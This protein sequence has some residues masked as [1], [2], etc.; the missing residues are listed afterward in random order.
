M[1]LD[2]GFE[3]PVRAGETNPFR[4]GFT[5][6]QNR[7]LAV[8]EEVAVVAQEHAENVDRGAFPAVG[9][10]AA[11]EHGLAA[12]PVAVGEG[13]GGA[14]AVAVVRAVERIAQGCGSTAMVLHMHLAVIQLLARAAETARD[15]ERIR[16][17]VANRLLCTY[18]TSERASGPRWWHMDSVAKRDGTG[19]TI[20]ASKSWSTSAGHADRYVVPMRSGPHAGPNDLTLFVISAG[21]GVVPVGDWDGSGLRGNSS[22]PVDFD[23][24]VGDDARLG[25]SGFGFELMLAYGLP[26]FQLGLA[27]VY[28]GIAQAAF[29]SAAAHAVTHR[30]GDT[31]KPKADAET[32]QSRLAEMRIEL[33][34][35][36][37][38]TYVLADATRR[39]DA[40]GIDFA[41]LDDDIGFLTSLAGAKIAACEAAASVTDQALKIC[42]GSAYKRGHIVERCYRDARAGSIMGPDDDSLK[43]LIGQ[44]LTGKPYPWSK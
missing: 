8:A 4:F 31:G 17:I 30:Y 34:T 1:T 10:S 7:W 39:L 5:E 38:L 22:T 21:P 11:W 40:D 43:L 28:L 37:C 33:D 27:G 3:S 24:V 32:T 20:A 29:D 36:R 26:S 14:D 44:R 12:M 19:W 42:G 13:G 25:P 23:L 41:D 35:A 18:A 9:I 16:D 15:R 2:H 6:E